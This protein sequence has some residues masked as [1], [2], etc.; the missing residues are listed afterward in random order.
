M[1]DV[2]ART[3][4][5]AFRGAVLLLCAVLS[6][7]AAERTYAAVPVAALALLALLDARVGALARRPLAVGLLEAAVAAGTVLLTDRDASPM[8]PYLMTAPLVMGLR[9]R[10]RDVLLVSLATAAVLGGDRLLVA[11][12]DGLATLSQWTLLGAGLGLVATRARQL[13][14]G[15]RPHRQAG[16]DEARG[17]IEQLRAVSRRLPGGLDV[18]TSA[19]TLLAR[20][21]AASGAAH[22]RS[23]VLVQPS[24]GSLVPIAVLGT[25]RVPW[26]APLT[27]PGPLRDAWESLR[28]VVDRRKPDVH[29]RR[30]GSTLAVVP[31]HDGSRPF[32]LVVVEAFD[33]D[34]FPP[35]VLQ[36]V[37]ACVDELALPLET[38]LL[39]EELNSAASA[40]ERDRLARE[41]HDGV[42]QDLAFI[43][44]QL[45]DLR[46][47]AAPVDADLEQRVVEL[48]G[49]LTTLVSD[50]RLSITDLKTSVSLDRGLG[51]ALSSYVRAVGTGGKLAVHL[52]LDESPFRLPGEQEALLMQV[53][54]VVAQDAR[55]TGEATNLWV[56]LKVDPPGARLVVQ[57][58]GPF[59]EPPEIA[60]FRDA[61]RRGEGTLRCD[62]RHSGG[63]R[64]AAT[65]GGGLDG[66]FR[67]DDRDARR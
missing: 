5:T 13:A 32:G 24:P 44:Y 28:P 23:A 21:A 41:M 27:D 51:S 67:P 2:D 53:A 54:H 39:F 11:S 65:L 43:G 64:V 36:A 17:L 8:L 14:F 26:R 34:A 33:P 7:L 55:R 15:D 1:G 50:L 40:A 19:E 52:S 58:D 16:Y 9:G 49:A 61:F 48:R 18:A 31:L 12:D 6:A 37:V 45:D 60:S 30:Q 25:R 35:D 10:V 62:E 20:V 38:A 4:V 63:V 42:A 3:T 59:T 46:R 56:D 47:R 29:G 22:G 66:G 57:H